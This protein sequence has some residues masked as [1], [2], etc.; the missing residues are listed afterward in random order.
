MSESDPGSQAAGP[1]AR[2]PHPQLRVLDVL[3]GTWR[4]EGCGLDGS[5]RFTGSVTRRW[6]PGGH[7]LVQE[8]SVDGQPHGGR[9]YIGYDHVRGCLRSL[10]FSEE[11]SGP[12]C[13]FALEYFWQVDHDALTIW[14]GEQGSPARFTGTIDRSAGVVDGEWEWPGGGYRATST[15]IGPPSRPAG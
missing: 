4:L 3:E 15:R 14:H 5:H 11:G 9:E 7:F 8:M 6:L 10:L 1:L 12:F 13:A 2:T